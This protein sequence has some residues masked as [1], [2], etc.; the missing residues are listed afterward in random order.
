[1]TVNIVVSCAG[2]SVLSDFEELKEE[3]VDEMFR[4]SFFSALMILKRF[5]PRMRQ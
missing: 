4:T 2:T 3:E 5:M 1:M